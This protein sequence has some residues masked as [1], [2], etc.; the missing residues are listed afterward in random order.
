MG[1]FSAAAG[2]GKKRL[3]TGRFSVFWQNFFCKFM[4]REV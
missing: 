2:K 4:Q 1:L 3:Q